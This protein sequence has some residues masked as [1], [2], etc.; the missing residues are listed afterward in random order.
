MGMVVVGTVTGVSTSPLW[1]AGPRGS[2]SWGQGSRKEKPQGVDRVAVTVIEEEELES[3]VLNF[4]GASF[5]Y[6]RTVSIGGTSFLLFTRRETESEAK[7]R[8]KT[9]RRWLLLPHAWVF[10]DRNQEVL[11]LG[12]DGKKPLKGGGLLSAPS[13][14][15][16]RP[17][18]EFE[19]QGIDFVTRKF[20]GDLELYVVKAFLSTVLSETG[21]GSLGLPAPL[22]D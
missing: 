16:A 9:V 15:G 17:P 11:V 22:A 7:F 10:T 1:E 19:E 4:F 8:P 6:E 2:P 18:K 20:P 3:T 13:S 14:D 12:R 5:G 21:L